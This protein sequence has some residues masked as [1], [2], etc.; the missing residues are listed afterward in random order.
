MDDQHK[1]TP[2]SDED[3]RAIRSMRTFRRAMAIATALFV[4]A[5]AI[6]AGIRSKSGDGGQRRPPA[7][8][9]PVER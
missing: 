8:S 6:A 5:M 1:Q 2:V 7:R 9:G 4:L 3:L